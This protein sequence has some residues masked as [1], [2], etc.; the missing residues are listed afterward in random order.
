MDNETGSKLKRT[1][2]FDQ[3]VELGGHLVGFAGWEMPLYYSSI[4]EEHMGVRR[5]AGLFDVSHMGEIILSGKRCE[6]DLDHLSTNRISGRE[7][8]SCTYTHFLDDGGRILDDTIAIRTGEEEF[9]IVP[10]ASKTAEILH[11]VSKNV[12]CDVMDVSDDVCCLALQG[13]GSV[14]VAGAM[15]PDAISLHSF[16]G[17][18]SSGKGSFMNNLENSSFF[19]SRTGYTGEEGFEL[20][21]HSRDAVRIWKEMLSSGASETL[22]AGLGARDSLRLEKGYLL[23]GTDFDGRQSTLETGYG[24]VISWDHDFIGRTALEEQKRTGAYSR[25]IC[26][27][28][29]GRSIPR[30]GDRFTFDGGAGTIT[31]GGFSPVLGTP[32]AMGYAKPVPAVSS[33]V[34]IDV[35]G[36]LLEG[37]VVKPP[38]V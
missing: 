26:I 36:R 29:Q 21:T 11:W 13:P 30:H 27:K 24:W 6:Q 31:S 2:L 38:F 14:N 32:V 23:S 20:F 35:R 9:V 15:V 1:P 19:I 12:R 8:G 18:F 34:S 17:M 4:L 25:L 37:I 33:K 28:V 5:K 7:T 22:P 10:N 3:H 16:R